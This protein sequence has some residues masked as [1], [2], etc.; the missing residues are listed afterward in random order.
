MRTFCL[1]GMGSSAPF[2]A[3]LARIRWTRSA[4]E[5]VLTAS[6]KIS[7]ASASIE[8]PWAA[9]RKRSFFLVSPSRLRIVKFATTLSLMIALTAVIAY[10][11]ILCLGSQAG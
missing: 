9:A 11:K 5:G 2:E 1:S 6:D 3:N 7:R 10:K 4:A 8:R